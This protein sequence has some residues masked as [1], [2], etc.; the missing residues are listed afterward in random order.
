VISQVK[1]DTD[2]WL[3]MES[4]IADHILYTNLTNQQTIA[5]VGA[6][7]TNDLVLK[8]KSAGFA[9]NEPYHLEGRNP[10]IHIGFAED[11]KVEKTTLEENLEKNALIQKE[12]LYD[13]DSTTPDAY[14]PQSMELTL[15]EDFGTPQLGSCVSSEHG[16]YS[17]NERG[18]TLKEENAVLLSQINEL[19]RQLDAQALCSIIEEEARPLSWDEFNNSRCKL[20]QNLSMENCE[21]LVLNSLRPT[22]GTLSL[23]DELHAAGM[24]VNFCNTFET[25]VLE[26]MS[27]TALENA[28]KSEIE[29]LKEELEKNCLA[30]AEKA[31]FELEIEKLQRDLKDA[32]FENERKAAL[33]SE[34]QQLR[35]D[36]S[37][38]R[39][40]NEEV[41]SLRWQI[42]TLKEEKASLEEELKWSES[43]L[44][45][46]ENGLQ[47]ST[48]ELTEQ[49]GA[50]SIAIH[51]EC[52]KQIVKLKND[53]EKINFTIKDTVVKEPVFE[54]KE[55]NETI[56][57][58]DSLSDKDSMNNKETE[59]LDEALFKIREHL[60]CKEKKLKDTQKELRIMKD[61]YTLTDKNSKNDEEM[62]KLRLDDALLK[63][64]EELESKEKELRKTQEELRIMKYIHTLTDKDT[65]NEEETGNL[66]LDE[67]LLKMR[68]ELESKEKELKETRGELKA[69]KETSSFTGNS[70]LN[71]ETENLILDEA[72]L[73]I[74]EELKIKENELKETQEEL[75][76]IKDS[77]SQKSEQLNHLLQKCEEEE[78]T[79][80]NRTVPSGMDK[81]IHTD[82]TDVKSEA[83]SQQ[84]L[85]NLEKTQEE[86]HAAQNKIKALLQENEDRGKY[87]EEKISAIIDEKD[88]E[89]EAVITNF[90]EKEEEYE[91]KISNL[92][93]AK[94]SLTDEDSASL[95]DVEEHH[96]KLMLFQCELE[97]Q[98][99][100]LYQKEKDLVEMK[101]LRLKAEGQLAD[102]SLRYET[103]MQEMK[104]II[105]GLEE[106]KDALT[107][108][109][110]AINKKLEELK[111][112][113]EASY[114]QQQKLEEDLDSALAD[115]EDQ[116][117]LVRSRGE[118][119]EKLT[120]YYEVKLN[121]KE[122]DSKPHINDNNDIMLRKLD[123]LEELKRDYNGK[124]AEC[125]KL[126][127]SLDNL[128]I[129]KSKTEEKLSSLNEEHS[130]ELAAYADFLEKRD[131]QIRHLEVD[132]KDKREEV[133]S[134]TSV[135]ETS[136]RELTLLRN[137]IRD[138]KQSAEKEEREHGILLE[139]IQS[140]MNDRVRDLEIE[141]QRLMRLHDEV[142]SDRNKMLDEISSKQAAAKDLQSDNESLKNFI[143]TIQ[144]EKIKLQEECCTKQNKI[145]EKNDKILAIK[146]AEQNLME[147]INCLKVTVQ[148]MNEEHDSANHQI[149][150][151]IDVI[152]KLELDMAERDKK[153]SQ[154]LEWEVELNL[155]DEELLKLKNETNTLGSHIQKVQ[156]ENED[157][158]KIQSKLENDITEKD[159]KISQSVEWE[160]ELNLRADEL[161]KLKNEVDTLS[162]HLQKVQSENEHLEV[163][164]CKLENDLDNLS[165][166]SNNSDNL[167]DKLP[168]G[169][170]KLQ[171]KQS[172]F[173]LQMKQCKEE[174][175]IH[176][177]E[178]KE[179]AEKLSEK[180]KDLENLH[181]Q[182]E[183][184]EMYKEKL[185]EEIA[186]IKTN[187]AKLTR[188]GDDLQNEANSLKSE[189]TTLKE[190]LRTTELE[191]LQQSHKLSAL[192]SEKDCLEQEYKSQQ[193]ANREQIDKLV[194][195]IEKLETEKSEK[196]QLIAGEKYT[197]IIVEENEMPSSFT[198]DLGSDSSSK[199]IVGSIQSGNSEILQ[200][201]EEKLDLLCCRKRSA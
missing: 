50:G 48:A 125:S 33:E 70:V 182:Y 161:Q 184:S 63:I 102:A 96:N 35:E 88:G 49:G 194:G 108:E 56:D 115:L 174:M 86:L 168:V 141:I 93:L 21:D 151:L 54:N 65:V 89:L 127:D 169:E 44:E 110:E 29:H 79:L 42:E 22:S 163:V 92:E 187:I 9:N 15:F 32:L 14:T 24:S 107:S 11:I 6:A 116:K 155:K 131:D 74:R 71:E 69:M 82:D 100:V 38:A 173:V 95:R 78:Q 66:R 106:N 77:Y 43:L 179:L 147:E 145:D 154:S 4:F 186:E 123:E 170:E 191:A 51:R 111:T 62:E 58:D 53:L 12:K 200:A 140:E 75:R 128:E 171:L 188:E 104:E 130:Q 135:V 23:A 17:E 156:S 67:A 172:D 105:K 16:S 59:K 3:Y 85:W 101:E 144:N 27:T 132:V 72:L 139:N 97:N 20:S 157:L 177:T 26:H 113:A 129:L 120:H 197:K 119:I 164:K 181:T 40:T 138:T 39:L 41:Y 126:K 158:K 73:K 112:S 117:A 148:E 19:K 142:C 185:L 84:K 136:E 1:T 176:V 103:H 133:R 122:V 114:V 134:L 60:E 165:R 64:R 68:K 166:I 47:S 192:Q 195:I 175:E 198:A 118:E 180:E 5:S 57:K 52:Q 143:Q 201:Y 76:T 167:Q 30:N 153:I 18:K 34:V 13:T 124:V 7:A 160:V 121:E 91:R 109:T 45:E 199:A 159:N 8:C 152:E 55:S 193:E 81:V 146:E 99:A 28:R 46:E 25:T 190:V 149:A 90:T 80:S 196:G 178:K 10:N 37:N 31:T 94:I 162:S 150:K 87:Y 98:K 137:E 183:A 61:C 189:V 36:L 2:A 83:D